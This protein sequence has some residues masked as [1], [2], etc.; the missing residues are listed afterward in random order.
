MLVFQHFHSFFVGGLSASEEE[1]EKQRM[2]ETMR[3]G[4]EMTIF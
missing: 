4:L 2:L 3:F 1:E